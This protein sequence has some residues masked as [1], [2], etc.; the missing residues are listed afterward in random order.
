MRARHL[1]PLLILAA[2]V[3][4]SA[5]ARQELVVTY[6]DCGQGDSILLQT[7][8]NKSILIDA[9]PLEASEGLDAGRDAIAPY[10]R[11]QGIRRLDVVV[12]SHPHMDHIGGFKY[13]LKNFSVGY[14]YDVGYSYPSPD[15]KD[16]LSLIQKK[17]IKYSVA[18][19]GDTLD[20]GPS[21][22]VRVLGPPRELPW[23]N[24][25]DNSM[26]IQ[27]QHGKVK[28]L[29]TGDIEKE[30][31]FEAVIRH[32]PTLESQ[33]FKAPH[34]AANTSSTKEFL[35]HVRPETVVVSC[36]RRNRFGHPNKKIIGRYE[37]YGLRVYRTDLQGHI[38]V[39]SDGKKY[40]VE[41]KAL[42]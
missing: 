18:R 35:D 31:E 1:L 37:D 3:V 7:P 8:D 26:L 28:F 38:R 22:K 6:L 4:P 36:G 30:A 23:D 10:L 9:G 24:P 11:E 16:V 12:F 39:I 21:L 20:W 40:R 5:W 15:Y 29:F 33:I 2:T 17:N 42:P 27:V 41:A 14:V 32:G 13:I 25:N 34:H 19:S